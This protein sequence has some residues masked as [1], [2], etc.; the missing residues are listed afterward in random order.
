MQW[1]RTR[2]ADGQRLWRGTLLA[3]GCRKGQQRWRDSQ[4]RSS[5]GRQC[6]N[7]HVHLNMLRRA[8][9]RGDRETAVVIAWLE[10]DALYRQRDHFLLAEDALA[11]GDQEP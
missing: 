8:D 6:S 7:S 2:I 9:V 5:I 11:G 4:N 10:P 3:I 1:K